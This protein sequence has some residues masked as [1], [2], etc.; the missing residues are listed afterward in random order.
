VMVVVA[1]VADATVVDVAV[2][3]AAV[4][5]TMTAQRMKAAETFHCQA[6]SPKTK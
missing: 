5:V 4:V 6:R 2:M 1:E 3:V